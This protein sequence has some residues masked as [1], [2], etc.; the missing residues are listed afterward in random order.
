V[1][2][3]IVGFGAV[4]RLASF[5]SYSLDAACSDAMKSA[6]A[7]TLIQGDAAVFLNNLLCLAK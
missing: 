7:K 6:S 3:A 2:E 1:P 5:V 4:L